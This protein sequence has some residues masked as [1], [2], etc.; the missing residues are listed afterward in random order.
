MNKMITPH[1]EN[2]IDAA[3]FR[4]ISRA[5]W[6]QGFALLGTLPSS[7]SR[8]PTI[9]KA[10][11]AIALDGVDDR[12]FIAAV[13]AVLQHKAGID[14]FYPSPPELRRVCEKQRWNRHYEELRAQDEARKALEELGRQMIENAKGDNQ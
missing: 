12:D 11:F 13:R 4:P 1:S 6:K 14:C 10:A 3:D 9:E 8:S 2:P 5:S 7:K